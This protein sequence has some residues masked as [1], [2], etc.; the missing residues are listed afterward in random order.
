MANSKDELYPVRRQI[1]QAV[2]SA[3]VKQASRISCGLLLGLA[4]HH[5]AAAELSVSGHGGVDSNPHRLSSELDPDAE[6]FSLVDVNVSNRF[7]SG[8][9]IKAQS[10]HAFYPGDDRADWSKSR[11]DLGFRDDFN[12]RKVRYEVSGDWTNRDQNYVSRT[13]G[14][15]AVS[16]GESIV[17]RYDYQQLN[18]NAGVS[19]TTEQDIRYRIR[20]QRRD[21]DYE[22]FSIP[23]LSDLDYQHDRY[24]FDI[25]YRF[26]DAHRVSAEI[27]E[28]R[29]EYKDRRV[30]DS[31][32]DDI[33]NT[34][35]EYDYSQYGLGYTYRPDSKLEFRLKA[36][37]S[38]RSDN[39]VGFNDS[40]YDSIYLSWRKTLG[41]ADE[42]R[43]SLLFSEFAY[44]DRSFSVDAD[45]E[46]ESFDNDG[47]TLKLGY[48]SRLQRN[49]GLS[50]LYGAEAQN[51]DSSDSRYVYD[52]VILTIGLKYDFL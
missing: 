22:D 13:T 27:G 39:G 34:D 35:L 20:Y 51:F 11:V 1:E 37:F 31:N 45:G 29:R 18:L 50:I 26:A 32:G 21:K 19:Y 43:L 15:D 42:I 24:R 28:T 3:V 16:G 12:D 2:A 6:A 52:R 9:S 8:V 44:D 14:E 23:G 7:D 40:T 48:Q 41:N 33:P 10:E 36:S 47:Y 30:Q 46:E 38:E 25:E 49:D 5:L 4:A 17:D